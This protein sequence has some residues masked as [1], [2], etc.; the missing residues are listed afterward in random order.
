MQVQK[1][2]KNRSFAC[3]GVWRRKHKEWSCQ[4]KRIKKKNMFLKYISDH[5]WHLASALG[6]ILQMGWVQSTVGWEMK[7]PTTTC[8]CKQGVGMAHICVHKSVCIWPKLSWRQRAS[9]DT[10]FLVPL[11]PSLHVL[12]V[13]D[14][15]S[16]PSRW[17]N[18]PPWV[19]KA[20]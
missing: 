2:Q 11:V 18:G 15:T 14:E 20:S 9:C 13:L 5:S 7:V 17:H 3:R 10:Y 6:Y 19:P 16:H 8:Q 4:A 1:Q 12:G